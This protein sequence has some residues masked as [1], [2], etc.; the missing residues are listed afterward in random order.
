MTTHLLTNEL[1]ELVTK[2]PRDVVIVLAAGVTIGALRGS[3]FAAQASWRG[4][5]ESG[6]EHAVALARLPA[7][8]GTR[9]R[10]MLG[11]DDAELWILA[12][13]KITSALGGRE[14][15]DLKSW[16]RATVGGFAGE[17][18]DR[19]VVDALGALAEQ[20]V[21][22]ATVNYDGILE[23]A[24]GLPPVTWRQ[25][26][27]VERVLRGA[28][29]G[30]LHLHGHW[31]DPASLIFGV[32]S[33]DDVVHDEHAR[34]VLRSMRMHKTFVLVGHGAGLSDPNWGSFLR[35]T[36]RVFAGAE[37]RH[38]RLVREEERARVQAEHPQEQRIYA[39]SYGR[40]HGDLGPFLRSLLPAG[41]GSTAVGGASTSSPAEATPSA[42][43]KTVL[44]RVNI[45]DRDDHW[46]EEDEARHL[47]GD[48]E[49]V[50]INVKMV[51]ERASATVA[52]WQSI[53]QLLEAA[54]K[55]AR[56]VKG[57][58]SIAV[59]GVAP[60]PA[61]AYLGQLLSRSP[62]RPIRFINRR[63]G[64]DAVDIVGPLA[65]IA[66]SDRDRFEVV[67]PS[68]FG[69][70][71]VALAIECSREYS[72]RDALLKP[73][74]EA[75]GEP[76]YCSYLIHDPVRSQFEDPMLAEDL[77]VLLRHVEDVL[78]WIGD[79]CPGLTGLVV[80]VGGPSWVAFWVG[81]RLNPNVCGLRIDFPNFI[82]GRG[83]V[84]ALASPMV[85]SPAEPK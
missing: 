50:C 6:I 76:L 1:K 63:R 80:A 51:I 45:G 42:P 46:L 75:V 27:R 35:W 44:I 15:G 66:R 78:K 79:E 54:V 84:P 43:A 67:K 52:Q 41:A 8:D 49:A 68:R 56:A 58:A 48:S 62:G 22:L 29:R 26:S 17:I 21:L 72:Y 61:F 59:A 7:A 11:S 64:S 31:E 85:R 20:G 9:L 47:A 12:A 32:R 71:R 74:L 53:A 40:D 33:Y 30:I 18:R 83:Y 23:A 65:A 77:P 36:E 19:S 5:L 28:E 24:T 55:E 14:G 60:L 69:S 3:P 73:V 39:V 34:E 37:Y 16:L 38:Y 2:S 4:L 10:E 13:E 70:G 81:L 82:P 25:A 57:M